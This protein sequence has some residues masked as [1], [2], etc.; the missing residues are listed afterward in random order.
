MGRLVGDG[1]IYL[2]AVDVV[3]EPDVQG[4]GVGRRLV[5]ELKVMVAEMRPAARLLL[6]SAPEVVPFYRQ[7]GFEPTGSTVLSPAS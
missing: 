1:A 4:R 3:V 5:E 6:V 7:L 2:L